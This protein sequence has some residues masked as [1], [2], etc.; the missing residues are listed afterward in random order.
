MFICADAAALRPRARHVHVDCPD[1]LAVAGH[2]DL[3][4]H[5]LFIA[6]DN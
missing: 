4:A 5:P 2:F 6:I 1:P 3:F